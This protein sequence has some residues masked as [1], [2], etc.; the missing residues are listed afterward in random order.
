MCAALAGILIGSGY[1]IA[2]ASLLTALLRELR[3]GAEE[4]TEVAGLGDS[5]CTARRRG[6]RLQITC[7]ET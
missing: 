2:M 7:I 3:S 5:K 4:V 6:T 1:T